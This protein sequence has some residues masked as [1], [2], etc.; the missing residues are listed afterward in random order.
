MKLHAMMALIGSTALVSSPAL[1]QQTTQG[2]Q[3]A[4]RDCAQLVQYLQ[5][6]DAQTGAGQTASPVDQRRTAA[7]Q[8]Q[9][10]QQDG[11]RERISLKEAQQLQQANNQQACRDAIQRLAQAGHDVRAQ[12]SAAPATPSA[13]QDGQRGAQVQVRQ[14]APE[15]T[16]R[17]ATPEIL[18]RQ[19]APT[20]TI[21]QPQPEIIVRMPSPDV[22]VSTAPPQVDVEPAKPQ[23]SVTRTGERQEAQVEPGGQPRVRYEQMGEAQVQYRRAEGE[24]SVR[25]ERQPT[26]DSRAGDARRPASNQAQAEDPARQATSA[27]TDRPVAAITAGRLEGMSVENAQGNSLGTVE[28]VLIAGNDDHHIV[29][30]YGGFLGIGQRSVSLPLDRVHLRSDTLIIPGMTDDQLRDL[31]QHEQ[32]A[33]LRR[34]DQGLRLSV[35][36]GRAD[37]MTGERAR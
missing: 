26:A 21:E 7:Q 13:R 36:V 17:Q 14:Q 15:V 22:N 30:A 6:S 5:R 3:G 4:Q 9:V 10:P 16:V 2:Q 12:A 25:Y 27:A 23:V 32:R 19:Q 20:I 29:I 28:Q 8:Q 31:P 33:G 18:V 11:Q 1:A 37:E 34:A 24:P 35:N